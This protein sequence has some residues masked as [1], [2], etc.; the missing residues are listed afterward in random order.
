MW[1]NVLT[2][3]MAALS[4]VK[5]SPAHISVP[6]PKDTAFC[7][8]GKHAEVTHTSTTTGNQFW[9][10]LLLRSL[11]P[12]MLQQIDLTQSLLMSTGH[13][14]KTCLSP[15]ENQ[16]QWGQIRSAGLI[17]EKD[18]TAEDTRFDHP[19]HKTCMNKDKPNKFNLW[20]W[21]EEKL[22]PRFFKTL[23][24]TP[25]MISWP[26]VKVTVTTPFSQTLSLQTPKMGKFQMLLKTLDWV[27]GGGL[28]AS[29]ELNKT[30]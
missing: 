26:G 22:K 21:Q 24:T 18:L 11:I 2:G 28:E 5:I 7:L 9:F 29:K 23:R 10:C 13:Q 4:A 8:T 19:K 15:E 14:R 20:Q 17:T 25:Q 3:T 27:G 30:H 16:C 1:M 6:V 12:L